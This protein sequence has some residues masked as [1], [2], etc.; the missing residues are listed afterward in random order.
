VIESNQGLAY[1]NTI[2]RR[3]FFIA[4]FIYASL[5]ETKA[6]RYT[7]S[8]PRGIRQLRYLTGGTRH[9]IKSWQLLQRHQDLN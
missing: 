5:L 4:P 2:V 6:K 3:D 7:L 8:A 9:S 1:V